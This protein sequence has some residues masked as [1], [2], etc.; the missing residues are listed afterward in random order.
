[1]HL[2][3][4]QEYK[5]QGVAIITGL[6]MESLTFCLLLLKSCYFQ[7]IQNEDICPFHFGSPPLFENKKNNTSKKCIVL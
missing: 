7:P 5:I 3:N 4:T 2:M 1:M 6:F